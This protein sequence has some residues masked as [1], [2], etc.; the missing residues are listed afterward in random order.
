M[1]NIGIIAT[2]LLVLLLGAVKII[3]DLL[4]FI[5]R[6]KE[7]LGEE[8]VQWLLKD[9]K[10]RRYIEQEKD[11]ENYKIDWKMVYSDIKLLWLRFILIITNHRYQRKNH[12]HNEY[13]KKSSI[14]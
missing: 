5:R 3:G 14:F 2:F 9:A 7:K 4:F 8:V 11:L 6:L 1:N 13:G 10:E 12:G